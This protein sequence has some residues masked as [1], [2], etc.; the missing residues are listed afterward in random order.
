MPRCDQ[1]CAS[2]GTQAA[3]PRMVSSRH[4][5]SSCRAARCRSARAKRRI[6]SLAVG[7]LLYS[8]HTRRSSA[9]VS[10]ASGRLRSHPRCNLSSSPSRFGSW[11]TL[12]SRHPVAT[13]LASRPLRRSVSS[14]SRSSST[15]C[16]AMCGLPGCLASLRPASS[17]TAAESPPAPSL[18]S[19]CRCRPASSQKCPRSWTNAR[20][21]LPSTPTKTIRRGATGLRR[22]IAVSRASGHHP[23]RRRGTWNRGGLRGASRE[24]PGLRARRSHRRGSSP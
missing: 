3:R 4:D 15:S 14:R 8:G 23:A 22:R 7:G 21:L 1:A 24:R 11:S 12:S 16:L 6:S 13:A 9:N 2:R 10:F 17:T 20:S 19:R 18:T 5:S